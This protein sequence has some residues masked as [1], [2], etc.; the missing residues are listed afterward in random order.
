MKGTV[1]RVVSGGAVAAVLMTVIALPASA[2]VVPPTAPLV[3]VA[4]PTEGAYY[5]RGSIWVTGVA[6]DP[7]ASA[8]DP[9]AGISRVQ[10]FAGDRNNPTNPTQATL[11]NRPGGYLRAATVA[12]TLGTSSAA[13]IAVVPAVP[14][15][16]CTASG[17]S[18]R[19]K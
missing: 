6:C 3:D 16:L 13:D 11:R 10:V 5:R 19:T 9:T 8:S 4:T 17:S 18:V 7:N 15:R 14:S 1:L 12:G 2:A